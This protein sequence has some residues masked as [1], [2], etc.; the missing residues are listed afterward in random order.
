[1]GSLTAAKL[2]GGPGRAGGRYTS[3]GV[4]V[5]MACADTF[6]AMGIGTSTYL[7]L[8]GNEGDPV[9]TLARAEEAIATHIGAIRSRSRDYWTEPWGFTDHRL[10]L[11]RAL[12]V[13]TGLAPEAVLQEALA[14]EAELGRVRV[15]GAGY[16]AR[17]I[18]IDLL[19]YGDCVVEAPGLV[20]PHPRLH[21]RAF[22]LAPL[23]D[24]A[25]DRHHP[26]L[27]RS[28]LELLNDLGRE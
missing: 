22:A 23:A 15:P 20:V 6:D 1:M 9:H 14:I 19:L 10:F 7:L 21:E 24:I 3:G 13:E 5:W 2:A 28:V 16:T 8:G 27:R 4:G 12:L 26:V 11:N 25:P 18:D 17:T